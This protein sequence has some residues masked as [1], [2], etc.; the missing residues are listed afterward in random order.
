[1]QT[2]WANFA[3]H[4]SQGP[5]KNWPELGVHGKINYIPTSGISITTASATDAKICGALNAL[6]GQ[7]VV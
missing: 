3:K 1:M 6:I 7:A 4:P 5:E 2:A